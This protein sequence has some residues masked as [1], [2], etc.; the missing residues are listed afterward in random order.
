MTHEGGDR[1]AQT[2]VRHG[3][4]SIL[5]IICPFK[6]LVTPT[7]ISHTWE[8]MASHKIHMEEDTP[9]LK[10]L[11]T[12]DS[13]LM[14]RFC[15]AGYSGAELAQINHCRMFLRVTTVS[16]IATGDRRSILQSALQGQRNPFQTDRYLWPQQG[17]LAKDNWKLWTVALTR[18]LVSR[19]PRALA[20]PLGRWLDNNTPWQ[21]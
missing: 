17:P 19:Q 16:D 8:F 4:P 21:T 14:S 13:F 6:D 12:N 18:A 9:N 7:C 20:V 5:S 2:G 1:T 11:R 15:D 10:L 3:G